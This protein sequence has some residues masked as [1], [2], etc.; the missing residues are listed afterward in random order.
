MSIFRKSFQEIQVSFQSDQNNGYLRHH[1]HTFMIM[2]RLIVLRIR[3][4]LDRI[5][6]KIK[7]QFMFPGLFFFRKSCRL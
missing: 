4:V 1:Q 7:T 3:N 6:E 5:F 2:S